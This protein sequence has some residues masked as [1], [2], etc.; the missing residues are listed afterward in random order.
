MDC[1]M[2]FGHNIYIDDSL[3]G[4]IGSNHDGSATLFIQGRKF[5]G[6]SSEGDISVDGKKM[7]HIDDN[8]DLYVHN[9]L[10]GEI[11]E[12]DGIR[13]FG[14]ALSDAIKG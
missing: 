3:V 7:G 5:A 13:F 9:T 1:T 11:D 12:T 2:T 10:V 8:G 14:S 4:Y 6:L